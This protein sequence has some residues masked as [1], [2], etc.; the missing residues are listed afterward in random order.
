[1]A[2]GRAHTLMRALM[3]AIC[4]ALSITASSTTVPTSAPTTAPSI[5]PPTA[6]ANSG[7]DGSGAPL[8]I[9]FATLGGAAVLA[10]AALAMATVVGVLLR[11]RSDPGAHGNVPTALA[12]AVE[13]TPAF[14]NSICGAD[15][16]IQQANRVAALTKPQIERLSPLVDH[17]AA[18][19]AARR[20]AQEHHAGVRTLARQLS[21]RLAPAAGAPAMGAV[22]LTIDVNSAS[23]E[24][25][26]TPLP[27]PIETPRHRADSHSSSEDFGDDANTLSPRSREHVE[28]R[29]IEKA[30]QFVAETHRRLSR[31]AIFTQA[32][33][34]LAGGDEG[35]EE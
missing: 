26:P 1:M 2:A 8:I 17:T 30:K 15:A 28:Q 32:M 35:E 13:L 14:N 4:L 25:A 33:S 29:R 23:I 11:R 34:G 9:V 21:G 10:A 7:D 19:E 6:R 20:K 5:A 22:A 18:R 3:C 31:H 27:T 24:N 12:D 16:S